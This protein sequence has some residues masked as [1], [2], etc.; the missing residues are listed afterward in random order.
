MQMEGAVALVT[1]ASSGIGAAAARRLAAAGCRILLLGRD[2]ARLDAVTRDVAGVPLVADLA[3]AGGPEDAAARARDALGHV[4]LLVNNAGVG[5][6]GE[7]AAMPDAAIGDL[8]AANL[9]APVRLT[10]ALLPAMV[11]RGRGHIVVVSSIAGRTGVGGE[12]VYAAT[13]AAAGVFADSLR[14]E[15]AGTNVGV[16]V[17]VPGVV[18]TPFFGR[19]GVPY[20][21]RWPR[22]IPPEQVAD[23]IVRAVARERP[24]V[25]APGWMRLPARLHGAL[26]GLYRHLAG[27]FG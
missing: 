8:V 19:R 5:W 23:A 16:S 25:F 9:L 24:E 17:V 15:L 10:R 18:D 21:R 2:A 11:A 27:R 26:P 22:P 6:A 7:F 12:A 1:G 20:G 3:A 4:D 13:K 14:Y